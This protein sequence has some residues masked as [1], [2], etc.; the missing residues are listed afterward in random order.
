MWAGRGK[1]KNQEAL[2]DGQDG[3]YKSRLCFLSLWAKE[4]ENMLSLGSLRCINFVPFYLVF[5]NGLKIQ[6]LARCCLSLMSLYS[7]GSLFVHRICKGRTS[8]IFQDSS[9]V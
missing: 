8:Q 4:R 7:Q 9:K 5:E 2:E 3:L 1:K 6:A